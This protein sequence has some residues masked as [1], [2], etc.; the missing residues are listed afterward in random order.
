MRRRMRHID[1][2][3]KYPR[4]HQEKWLKKLISTAKKTQWGKKFDYSNI[5]NYSDFKKQ[6]PISNYEELLPE[7]Q[8]VRNG[9]QNV[10]WNS[11]TKW[12]AKS[13]GTSD[14]KSKYI[15]VTQESLIDCHFKG[16]KDMLTFYCNNFPETKIYS[17]KSITMGGSFETKNKVG[18]LSAIILEQLPNWV[19]SHQTPNK[20]IRLM[21]DFE[22]KIDRMAKITAK[23]NV[24]NISGVPSWTLILLQRILE[25]TGAKNMHEV[26]PN[27]EVYM[28][29]GINFN[30]YRSQFEKLFPNGINYLEIYNASEGS[31]GIQ[32]QKNSDEML[33]MLNYGIFYEFI[34]AKSMNYQET[35]PIW[36]VQTGVSYA[37]VI[38]TNSGLWRYLIGDT[39]T[40]TSTTPYRIK[41]TGRTSQFINAFGEELTMDN[42]SKALKY[43]CQKTASTITDYTVVPLFMENG[44]KGAHEWYIE[45]LNKPE[46]LDLFQ[47]YLDNSLKNLNSDYEAKRYKSMALNPPVIKSLKKGFFYNWMKSNRKLGRQF[48]VPRLNNDR[49]IIKSMFPSN[50]F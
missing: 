36:E 50:E 23:E 3:N 8:K 29:G 35:I 7:I 5:N 40:F 15:P 49:R 32:D 37:I 46:N 9:E 31:F 33:L 17:G 4:V 2:V 14:S 6:V 21:N 45:F 28:H 47:K 24:T 20:E 34:P 42:A 25:N 12:F 38:S 39:V 10:L 11:P 19:T 16:G 44:K 27:L 48:K 18:D 13:S 41:I 26:W 30:P 43:A 22:R 1:I